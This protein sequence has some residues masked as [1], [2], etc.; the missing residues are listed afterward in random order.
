M[1]RNSLADLMKGLAVLLMV[2]VH[3]MELFARQEVYDSLAGKVSLFLGGPF[4]A[5]VFLAVMGYFLAVSGRSFAEMLWRGTELIL[6]GILLNVGLNFHLLLKIYN[7]V[8]LDDP[9]QYIFGADI[10]FIAG[11]SIIFI[12]ILKIKLKAGM[13]PIL[14]LMLAVAALPLVIPENIGERD[15][16]TYLLSF[17]YLK[18]EWS[19]FP[20]IPWFSYALLG[21]A[22]RQFQK[23]YTGHYEGLRSRAPFI[24]LVVSLALALTSFYPV[25]IITHL[26]SY[27]HHN[28][29]T[30]LWI[31]LFILFLMIIL[32]IMEKEWGRNWFFAYLKW[33]GKEVTVMYVFQW[34]IIGNLA[35]WLYK[36]QHPIWL[37]LWFAGILALSSL[38][39]YLYT[40]L[41]NRKMYGKTFGAG[42]R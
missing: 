14:G 13:L 12:S 18:T 22:F 27:Y 42:H 9:W 25:R 11:F 33:L 16:W 17:F 4:A 23:D 2:Q 5:P 34:L 39:T 3:I 30:F 7:G 15:F 40:L 36:S 24:L 21:F 29:L 1:K 10:L 31:S 20:V 28:I 32:D 6:L 26:P 37:V 41:K 19:Y 35:T 8:I 38:L